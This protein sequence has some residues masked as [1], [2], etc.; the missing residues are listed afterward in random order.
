MQNASWIT[1]LDLLSQSD[2]AVIALGW[3]SRGVS[4]PH[5]IGERYQY[6]ITQSS[7][8]GLTLT[9][10]IAALSNNQN[11]DTIDI[12]SHSFGTNVALF[13][14][15]ELSIRPNYLVKIS[16][17]ILANG[18]APLSYCIKYLKNI[19]KIRTSS[20][21]FAQVSIP[22]IYN[23][24]LDGDG[25]IG[26]AN[27]ANR[28]YDDYGDMFEASI[29]KTEVTVGLPQVVQSIPLPP[30]SRSKPHPTNF[31]D[32]LLHT[33]LPQPEG[34]RAIGQRLEWQIA[35][36]SWHNISLN[37]P[38]T[39]LG[40]RKYPVTGVFPGGVFLGFP[41]GLQNH[42]VILGTGDNAE[43]VKYFLNGF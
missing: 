24:F 33:I 43:F 27:S 29:R 23:I 17:V 5:Y 18:A 12:I 34:N 20:S 26:D 4:V 9:A 21:E 16:K 3:F 42:Y 7:Y 2:D 38:R 1:N 41:N 10:L 32:D 6:T 22:N 25:P 31:L 11:I 36:P 35:D 39:W 14:L 30:S 8:P 15:N 28:Y 19:A 40:Y 13:A 37:D